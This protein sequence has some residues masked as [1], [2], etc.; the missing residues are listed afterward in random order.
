[1]ASFAARET[2]LA[3]WTSRAKS[4]VSSLG[5]LVV[6]GALSELRRS[7]VHGVLISAIAGWLAWLAHRRRS[8]AGVLA[9]TALGLDLAVANARLVWSVPQAVFDRMPEAVRQ[10]ELAELARPSPGPFR[11]HRMPHWFPYAWSKRSSSDRLAEIITWERD[12]L[13][14]LYGLPEH[15]SYTMTKGAL[16]LYD[17]LWFFRPRMV[18]AEGPVAEMLGTSPGSPLLYHPRRGFDLWGTRYFLLPVRSDGWAEENRAYASFL[19]G[20]EMVYPKLEEF[21]GSDRERQQWMERWR[22]E[23]DWQLFRSKTA[24]PRAWAVHDARFQKPIMGLDPADRDRPMRALLFQNDAFWHDP[25]LPVFDTRQAALIETDQKQE[26][27]PYLPGGPTGEEESVVVVEHLPQRVVIE[28]SL[29]RPGLV[30][31]ADVYYPGWSLEVDGKP[32]SIL[33]AN[34]MMRGAAVQSGLHRLVY[35]YNPMSFRIGTLISAGALLTVLGIA[36]F[37]RRTQRTAST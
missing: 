36:Q 8:L 7:L 33:R 12:T 16:E 20:I 3:F 2:I 25:N 27:A 30:I 34:R 9:V 29:S 24:Y 13:Q 4:A 28:V 21:E 11:V 5:P 19:Q 22:E 35:R 32:A 1:V 10:I 15:V 6:E 31:L 18:R 14:P 17:Y 37:A 23:H 26:L